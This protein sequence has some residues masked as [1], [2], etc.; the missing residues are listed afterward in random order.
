M[1]V[2][3]GNLR[4]DDSNEIRGSVHRDDT[5]DKM[6]TLTQTYE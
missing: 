4:F 3:N 1:D 6:L 2:W 5:Q